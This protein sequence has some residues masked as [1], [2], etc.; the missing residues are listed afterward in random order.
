MKE[1]DVKNA[2]KAARNCQKQEDYLYEK[3]EQSEYIMKQT[4]RKLNERRIK[5]IGFEIRV[6]N[7]KNHHFL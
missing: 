5:N 2:Y 6:N 3:M 4:V 7:E 1:T